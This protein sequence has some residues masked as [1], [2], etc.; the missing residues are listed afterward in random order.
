MLAL[1]SIID[2]SHIIIFK[3]YILTQGVVDTSVYRTILLPRQ[4][5]ITVCGN[6]YLQRSG[7]AMILDS[8]FDTK[9]LIC[10]ESGPHVQ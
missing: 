2:G 1:E 10:A 5:N 3:S 7:E 9:K 8:K 6:H 4:Y